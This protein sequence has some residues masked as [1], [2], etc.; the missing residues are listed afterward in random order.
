MWRR[1]GWVLLLLPQWVA[2]EEMRFSYGLQS[3]LWEEFDSGGGKLLDET[4]FRHVF[5]LYAENSVAPTWQSDLS[6]HM[7]IGRV[8]YDGQTQTGTPVSTDTDYLGYGL[9]VGFSYFPGQVPTGKAAGL[10]GRLALGMNN[11]NRTLLGAGGYQEN[12]RTTYGRVAALYTIPLAWRVELGARLPMATS[13]RVD[14]SAFGY[15]QEVNLK[16]KGQPSLYVTWHYQI[17][18][19]FG[20]NLDYDGYRFARSDDDIVYNT[21]D[22]TYYAVHQPRSEMHTLGLAITISF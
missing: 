8:A 12:Y 5:A 10:G 13:E 9:E 7:T 15:A 14:L 2:A 20:F 21:L 22:G 3:F 1:I 11:W 4:G 16:P 18:K 6:A 17:N 19:R